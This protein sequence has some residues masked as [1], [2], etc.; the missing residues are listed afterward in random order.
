MLYYISVLYFYLYILFYY[1]N[2]YIYIF[3]HYYALLQLTNCVIVNEYWKID[4]WNIK[5]NICL[6]KI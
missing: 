3:T 5:E 6:R 2:I 1:I 4:Y